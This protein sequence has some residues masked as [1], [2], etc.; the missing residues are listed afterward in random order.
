QRAPLV[1]TA[2]SSPRP[3]QARTLSSPTRS[4]RASSGTVRPV[5]GGGVVGGAERGVLATAPALREL[6]GRLGRSVPAGAGL[7]L[8]PQHFQHAAGGPGQF[9][10]GPSLRFSGVGGAAAHAL[11][12]RCTHLGH[13][14]RAKR[15]NTLEVQRDRISGIIPE[16]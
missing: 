11:V 16:T 8:H 6:E 1:L 2:P 14:E 9:L 15:T 5:A 3:I 7:S 10:P 12:G 13:L 4:R